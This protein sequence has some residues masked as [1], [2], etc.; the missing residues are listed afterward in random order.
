MTQAVWRGVFLVTRSRLSNTK[1]RRVIVIACATRFTITPRPLIQF[2]SV[3]MVVNTRSKISSLLYTMVFSLDP[4]A[5]ICPMHLWR[6][7]R[8]ARHH[9]CPLAPATLATVLIVQMLR[10][11]ARRPIP[12]CQIC[13]SQRITSS[14]QVTSRIGSP[15]VRMRIIVAIL[16]MTAVPRVGATGAR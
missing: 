5:S 9:Q 13:Q 3:Q 1:T 15:M 7:A 4:L 14:T 16:S 6:G 10:V 8:R 11:V 12:V 2:Q